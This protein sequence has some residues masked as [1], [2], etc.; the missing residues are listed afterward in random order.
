MLFEKLF[1]LK[2]KL[3]LYLGHLF[4]L[5]KQLLIDSFFGAKSF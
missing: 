1:G 2:I 4:A 5:M 3:Y